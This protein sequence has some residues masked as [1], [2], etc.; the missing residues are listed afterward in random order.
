MHHFLNAVRHTANQIF[1]FQYFPRPG[2]LLIA[3][4]QNLWLGWFFSRSQCSF[5]L[6]KGL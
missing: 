3:V 5:P 4:L 2:K 1:V 6:F